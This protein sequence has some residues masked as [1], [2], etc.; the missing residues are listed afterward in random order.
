MY[1]SF[2]NIQKQNSFQEI[3]LTV[4]PGLSREQKLCYTARGP[5]P[6]VLGNFWTTSGF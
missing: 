6:I 5:V 2:L 1:F 4:A 3:T